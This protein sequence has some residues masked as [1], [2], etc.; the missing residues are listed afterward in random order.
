MTEI[1][2]IKWHEKGY[3]NWKKSIDIHEKRILKE[4]EEIKEDKRGLNF[5]KFQ[6]DEAKKENKLKFDRD[7]FRIKRLNK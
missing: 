4:L 3:N 2:T 5:L 1:N 6:I 7:K